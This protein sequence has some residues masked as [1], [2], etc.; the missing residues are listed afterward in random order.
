MSSHSVAHSVRCAWAALLW[1]P[2]GCPYL[3]QQ[4]ME[5][6]GGKDG[7]HIRLW[8]HPFQVIGINRMLPC[9][10]ADRLQTDMRSAFGKPQ[11]TVARVHIAQVMMPDCTRLQNKEHVIQALFPAEFKFPGRQKISIFWGFTQFNADEFE[12]MVAEKLLLLVG[13]GVRYIPNRGPLDRCGPCTQESISAVPSIIMLTNKCCLENTFSK[14]KM[15][16][17]ISNIE[18]AFQTLLSELHFLNTARKKYCYVLFVFI[19]FRT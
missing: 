10:G 9:A 13:C 7:F 14:K 11:G 2:R 12:N 5:K 18:I 19:K 4:Y 8:L 1:C 15:Y 6:S 17:Y 3:W 16:T